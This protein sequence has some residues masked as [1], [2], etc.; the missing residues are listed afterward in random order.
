MPRATPPSLPPS[1]PS[2]AP[3][4]RRAFRALSA[5]LAA[6]RAASFGVRLWL[7]ILVLALCVGAFTYWRVRV[8][9]DGVAHH[10]G[11]GTAAGRLALVL[12]ACALAGGV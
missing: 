6:R 8:P 12:A 5:R 10:A 1:T 11:Q 3:D 4:H 9:L 2:A 7:V